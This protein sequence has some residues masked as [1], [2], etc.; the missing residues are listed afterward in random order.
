MKLPVPTLLPAVMVKAQELPE[1]SGCWT[2]RLAETP[3]AAPQE[4]L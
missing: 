1:G 2:V 4:R 3:V